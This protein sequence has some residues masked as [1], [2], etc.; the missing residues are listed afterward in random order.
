VRFPWEDGWS[1]CDNYADFAAYFP[2][3]NPAQPVPA[4]LDNPGWNSGCTIRAS[5]L[6][7][8]DVLNR[9]DALAP[10]G[11]VLVV[12]IFYNYPPLLKLPIFSN[13]EFLGVTYSIIPDPIP[14]Y[15]YTVMPLSSAEPTPVH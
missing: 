15:V 5:Q 12:E 7:T 11:G 13:G 4:E 14:L 10:P 9:M 2:G 1:L 6:T 8:T 3:L